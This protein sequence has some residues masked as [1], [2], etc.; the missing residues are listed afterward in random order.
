[1]CGSARESQKNYD[2]YIRQLGPDVYFL[3]NTVKEDD[4]QTKRW[5][6]SDRWFEGFTWSSDCDAWEICIGLCDEGSEGSEFENDLDLPCGSH[7]SP[8][9]LNIRS[10]SG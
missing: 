5:N 10:W 7:M 8:E 6:I 9:L 2:N 4:T 1:M 3:E